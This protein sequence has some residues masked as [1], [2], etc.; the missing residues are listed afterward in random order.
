MQNDGRE[1]VLMEFLGGKVDK[2]APKGRYERESTTRAL[3]RVPK[4]TD[5]PSDHAPPFLLVCQNAIDGIIR[6]KRWSFQ[7]FNNKWASLILAHNE[8]TK[9][10]FVVKVWNPCKM[11]KMRGEATEGSSSVCLLKM[12]G[13]PT[14]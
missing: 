10:S 5:L 4:A 2:V 12:R 6:S 1:P 13:N 3:V 8:K 7:G 9:L 14:I 11:L